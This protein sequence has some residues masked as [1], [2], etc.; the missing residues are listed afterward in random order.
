MCGE[1]IKNSK[2]L[3]D[4]IKYLLAEQPLLGELAVE[5]RYYLH[6]KNKA[7]WLAK[8]WIAKDLVPEITFSR[9]AW[10]S[11][12]DEVTRTLLCHEIWHVLLQH[13]VQQTRDRMRM[14]IAQDLAINEN[15]LEMEPLRS[16][17][18][19]PVTPSLFGLPKNLTWVQYLQ[20]VPEGAGR[21][22]EDDE[23]DGEWE[24]VDPDDI[25]AGEDYTVRLKNGKEV[26]VRVSDSLPSEPMT[27]EQRAKVREI[28][29]RAY[30]RM[31]GNIPGNLV[32]FFSDWFSAGEVPWQ[33][34][35]AQFVSNSIRSYRYTTWDKRNRKLPWV[36]PGRR[37]MYK[38][39]GVVANDVSGSMSDENYRDAVG[40]VCSMLRRTEV[41][42]VGMAFDTE[43]KGVVELRTVED[44][45]ENW[46][47]R[48]G[49]GGTDFRPVLE[50]AREYRP[51]F[52]VIFTDAEGPWP[53]KS[54]GYPL[55]VVFFGDRK[56]QVPGYGKVV[57]TKR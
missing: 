29:Q 33:R 52:T 27:L 50:Q 1:R 42:L 47:R 3:T 55:L 11:C 2:R 35:L 10:L 54:P 41:E 31:A 5:A 57:Y 30:K 38:A 23:D 24:E 26:T 56:E 12:S 51:A 6:H 21:G 8:V 9:Y 53:E 39:K 40:E 16:V 36:V 18:G 43:V 49:Y 7:K 44:V 15:L 20:Y 4:I 46:G 34:V 17:K 25:E 37:T 22:G 45:K 48:E 32:Q 19:V 28:V 13:T 14:N